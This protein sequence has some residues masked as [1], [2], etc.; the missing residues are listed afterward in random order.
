M[1]TITEPAVAELKKIMAEN[2][3]DGLQAVLAQT[4]CSVSPVFQMVRF[5]E[6]DEPVEISG[7]KILMDD[8]TKA[9]VDEAIIDVQDGELMVFMP[10]QGGGCCGGH[11]G[12]DH[13]GGCC[14]GH[15]DHDHDGGCCGGHGDHDHDGGC[16]GGHGD[17]DHDGGCCGG[18]GDHGH[19]GGCCGGHGDHEG[20]CCHNE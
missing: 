1:L 5:D 18:H 3:A 6:G 2:G 10:A 14:G 8:D 19:D 16:C 9:V 20:G 11:G 4:C 7:I 12:H 13:D 15:G 17:H